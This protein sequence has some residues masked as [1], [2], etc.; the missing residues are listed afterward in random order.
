MIAVLAVGTFV[1]CGITEPSPPVDAGERSDTFAK[2]DRAEVDVARP[3]VTADVM[4]WPDAGRDDDVGP[5]ADSTPRDAADIDPTV[6]DALADAAPSDVAD[7]DAA[8]RDAPDGDGGCQCIP[9]DVEAGDQPV[10]TT[11]LPCFLK[12]DFW[13]YD[14]AAYAADPCFGLRGSSPATIIGH[15]SEGTYAERNLIGVW[16]SNLTGSV[17][18]G[19]FYD[20][21]TKALLGAV[22]TGNG[23]DP[24]SCTSRPGPGNW[25]ITVHA[26]VL[27][28]CDIR[29]TGVSCS[30][31]SG[32]EVCGPPEAGMADADAGRDDAYDVDANDAT[33]TNADAE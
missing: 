19:Y 28:D 26:G 13:G 27:P 7:A 1:A 2:E 12:G 8:F 14:Y 11:S 23:S 32:R 29:S 20:A 16:T 9:W 10:A 30:A 4:H 15:R 33:T 6:Q 3:D 25:Y 22:R 21:T 17:R 24:L 31:T 5:A 18:F